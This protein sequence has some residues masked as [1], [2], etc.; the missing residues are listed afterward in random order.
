MIGL[1]QEEFHVLGLDGRKRVVVHSIAAIGG[2]NVVYIDPR[3]VFRGLV[4][5][6][7][8]S[9]IVAHNHPSGSPEPSATDV[10]LTRRLADAGALLGIELVDHVVI[11]REGYFS[12]AQDH[13]LAR[14]ALP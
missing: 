3:D 12:F 11:G 1:E 4:R 5:G 13:E 2:C 14:R 7:V 9:A 8:D 10:D 6:A